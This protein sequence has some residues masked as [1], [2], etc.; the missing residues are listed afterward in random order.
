MEDK[1]CFL[2]GDNDIKADILACLTNA[3]DQ[4]IRYYGVKRFILSPGGDF[5]RLSRQ[6]L[7][8]LKQ[9]FPD[10]AYYLL[11]ETCGR[12]EAIKN[13]TFMITYPWQANGRDMLLLEYAKTRQVKGWIYITV[14]D[15]HGIFEKAD[16]EHYLRGI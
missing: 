11:P 13:C 14:L 8:T 7:D 6:A 1:I 2:I 10:I 16:T 5:Y 3:L 4:H 12:K 9:S 15:E